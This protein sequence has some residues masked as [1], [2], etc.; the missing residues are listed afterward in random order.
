MPALFPPSYLPSVGDNSTTQL[1]DKIV[2]MIFE[3]LIID[4]ANHT[5]SGPGFV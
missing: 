1:V 2:T 3:F 5:I 4:K